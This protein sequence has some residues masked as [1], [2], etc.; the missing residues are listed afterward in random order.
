MM[1][2]KEFTHIWKFLEAIKNLAVT[3]LEQDCQLCEARRMLQDNNRSRSVFE[4]C[5]R[6]VMRYTAL[7]ASVWSPQRR[8]DGTFPEKC[9]DEPLP[10]T[11]TQIRFVY[12]VYHGRKSQGL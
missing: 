10:L 2:T 9:E 4:Q 12:P 7:S 5:S 8:I 6:L 11:R 3:Y 1:P